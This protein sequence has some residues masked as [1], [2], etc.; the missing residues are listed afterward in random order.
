M[1]AVT[2]RKRLEEEVVIAEGRVK[3]GEAQVEMLQKEL[4]EVEK[5]E[6]G[7]VVKG[8]GGGMNTIVTLAKDRIE[9]LRRMLTTVKTQR[10]VAVER[11]KELEGIL[12][13]F[14]EEYNPNF[15]DEGVKRAVR[16]WEEYAAKKKDEKGHSLKESEEGLAQESDLEAVLNE[17]DGG[18]NWDEFLVSST[19]ESDV[20]HRMYS[21]S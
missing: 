19:P 2:M 21:P 1:E 17:D 6:R 11:M 10:D 9:E 18:I 20:E 8:A 15:N 12:G 3:A 7:R 4:E 14:R 13:K 5:K 16:S